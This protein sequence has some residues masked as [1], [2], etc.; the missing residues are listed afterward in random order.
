MLKGRLRASILLLCLSMK[1]RRMYIIIF[2]IVIV[3]HLASGK[4][5]GADLY[6]IKLNDDNTISDQYQPRIASGRNGDMVVVWTD[7]RNGE[8]DIYYQ[9][10]DTSGIKD[11]A[12]R[13]LN[14]DINSSIQMEPAVAAFSSGHYLSVWKDY[15]NG[16]YPFGPNIYASIMDS[17]GFENNF[18]VTTEL[19]NVI[20]E[21][22]DAAVLKSGSAVV[23]WADYRNNN[24]DIYGR[25]ISSAGAPIGS[26]FKINSETIVSQQHSPHVAALGGG[27]FVV[28]WYDNRLGNDDI[29]FQRFDSLAAAVGG[30]IRAGD[31]LTGAKQAFPDVAADGRGRF[32]VGW[33]DWRNGVYPANPDVYLRRF[34]STGTALALSRKVNGNDN[35]R[36]QRDVALCADYLGNVAVVWADSVSGQY[37]I[38]AQIIDHNGLSSG[39]N[40][41]VHENIDGRQL[42][43]DVA[44]D[45]YKLLFTWAD[46]RAGNFDVYLTIKNFNNPG[47][48]PVPASLAF[49]M[50]EGGSLP[51]SQT[52]T[53]SNNGL[54]TINWSAVAETDWLS[55]TPST[56]ITPANIE[57]SIA[58][59]TLSY[60][61]YTG[62][63]KL[64]DN[65]AGDSSRAVSVALTV[66]APLLE[67]SPDTVRFRIL[68]KLGDPEPQPI[69][70]DNSGSGV[71]TWNASESVS[72]MSLDATNGTQ[73]ETLFV[74]I[75]TADLIPG[76][77]SAAVEFISSEAA[78]S[79]ETVW[80]YAELLDGLS[81]IDPVPDSFIF[82]ATAGATLNGLTRIQNSGDGSLGWTAIPADNWIDIDRASGSDND[83]INITIETS[84][85]AT[86]YHHSGLSIIDS[87]SFNV[88][89]FIPIDIFL[90]SSDT[91]QFMNTNVMPG[92]TGLVPV[93][94]TLS[95][96]ARGGYVPF[97]YDSSTAALDSI[98]INE[99]NLPDF[100]TYYTSVQTGGT[101]EFGFRVADS[102]LNDSTIPAGT[103]H[104]ADIF[105]TAGESDAFNVIDTVYSDSSGSYI[106]GES[107]IKQVPKV[108]SGTMMIG[109]PTD[110][111]DDHDAVLPRQISLGQNYPNPFN[112]R[113]VIEISLPRTEHVEINVY[114][115]LGQEVVV[116]HNDVLSAGRHKLV[117][118]GSLKGGETAPSGIYFYK[119]T[120]SESSQ[121]RKMALIK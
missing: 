59:D 55:V 11:G 119:M 13:K 19:T 121:V 46:Y 87:A 111:P 94:L 32:Y 105:F 3:L 72:W 58:A 40:F 62:E 61:T 109:N 49:V 8:S 116:L 91:V 69:V 65:D 36:T 89:V 88:E 2:V 92:L 48:I 24:W 75:S 42:Q 117:W 57:I 101:G 21:S 60:G 114:N 99:S 83:T 113:T 41:L 100:V 81:C 118:D 86:G 23:V 45:G 50:E 35:G 104:I 103:Y 34:D 37:D 6:D 107:S 120:A 70:I 95:S 96:A 112:L 98:V 30:N 12:N 18:N 73:G 82:N 79:P 14:D 17:S 74:N 52:A 9:I 22:P 43:P 106:L 68:Q 25:R 5:A 26:S 38:M 84:T 93:Y 31:D 29:F 77:N 63:I 10:I 28:V 115:I 44:T 47:L 16:E 1:S 27:G 71:L 64:I 97:G 53:L 66:T 15:R 76:D 67:L 108:I 90:S 20:C 80:V 54:G 33:I 51:A 4:A 110:V 56:G 85:L 7:K 39:S 78:N 102:V